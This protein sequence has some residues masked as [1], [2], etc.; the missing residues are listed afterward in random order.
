MFPEPVISVC[1]RKEEKDG[2]CSLLF[3][4]I[5]GVHLRGMTPALEGSTNWNSLDEKGGKA[6]VGVG[7]ERGVT[8]HI[9]GPQTPLLLGNL[10]SA[11]QT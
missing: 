3:S 10:L 6:R 9:P 5:S 11:A 1:S 4:C 2:L 7:K 8:I